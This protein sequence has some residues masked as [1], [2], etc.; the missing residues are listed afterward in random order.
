MGGE[1][2]DGQGG[3]DEQDR[4]QGRHEVRPVRSAVGRREIGMGSVGTARPD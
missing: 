1:V 2:A 4:R 3:S